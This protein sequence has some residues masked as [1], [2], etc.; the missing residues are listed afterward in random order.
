[1][2][3]YLGPAWKCETCQSIDYGRTGRPWSCPLCGVET[4]DHCLDRYSVCKTCGKGKTD[5]ELILLT[6]WDE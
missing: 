6:E 2:A 3:I 1:M 4:C 5:E